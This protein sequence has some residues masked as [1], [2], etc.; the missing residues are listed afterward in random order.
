[1]EDTGIIAFLILGAVAGWLAGKIM[2][3][4]G[5][6]LIGNIIVGIVGAV[7]GGSI[8]GLIGISAAGFIGQLVTA[9]L[10]AVILLFIV[11]LIKK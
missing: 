6:G 2:R 10:G 3:G 5:M 11:G 7:I 4:G 8:T 9:T 1:M